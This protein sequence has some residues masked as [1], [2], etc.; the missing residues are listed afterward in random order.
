MLQINKV[1]PGK[2]KE[3]RVQYNKIY[4]MDKNN[5][6]FKEEQKQMLNDINKQHLI[7]I[8][9]EYRRVKHELDFKKRYYG[10]K[11]ILKLEEKNGMY[12]FQFYEIDSHNRYFSL[13]YS[14]LVQLTKNEVEAFLY[15]HS[16]NYPYQLGKEDTD[17]FNHDV[18]LYSDEFLDI[19]F[20]CTSNLNIT[21]LSDMEAI[22]KVYYYG[23]KNQLIKK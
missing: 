13:L 3:I 19:E 18:I 14:S 7:H 16:K 1:K 23:E 11:L 20:L 12:H 6:F 2:A 9:Y 10:H 8:L 15:A 21:K 5:D 17:V 22:Y 4:E